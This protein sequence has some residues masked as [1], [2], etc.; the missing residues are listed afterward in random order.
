MAST[1]PEIRMT[2]KTLA[3]KGMPKRRIARELSLSEGTVRYHLRRLAAGANDGRARQQCRASAYRAAIDHWLEQHGAAPTNV[4]AL[5][6]WLVAKHGYPGS[7]RSV[8]T[9]DRPRTVAT[10]LPSA[11]C[12]WRNLPAAGTAAGIW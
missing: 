7:L 11:D 10:A 6:D 2:I 1:D 4:A 12:A 5:H 9:C 3:A 8:H